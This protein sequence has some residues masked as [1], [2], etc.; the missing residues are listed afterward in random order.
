MRHLVQLDFS[1]PTWAQAHEFAQ[2]A[3]ISEDGIVDLVVFGNPVRLYSLKTV[4]FDDFTHRIGFPADPAASRNGNCWLCS[5]KLSNELPGIWDAAIEDFDG[6]GHLDMYLARPQRPDSEVIQT[7][8]FEVRGT[9]AESR[10][11]G[12]AKTLR[13]QT[14]SHVTFQLNIPWDLPSNPFATPLQV[15]IGSSRKHS[16]TAP[17]TVTS[18]DA[19]VR[20]MVLG[21]ASTDTRSL[22]QI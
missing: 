18:D 20:E 10:G 19:S 12:E 6:D 11:T 8:P 5:P 7:T 14:R 3:D 1:L 4:P 17:F 2:L 9:F 15:T 16:A 22:D 21:P 13:F